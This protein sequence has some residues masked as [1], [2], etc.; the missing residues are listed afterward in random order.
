MENVE[1]PPDAASPPPPLPPKPVVA[2]FDVEAA[3]VAGEAA[4]DSAPLLDGGGDAPHRGAA[5][6]IFAG[7]AALTVGPLLAAGGALHAALPSALQ[8]HTRAGA[9]ALQHGAGVLGAGLK[10]GAVAARDGFVQA[11]T[12][13]VAAMPQEVKDG[14]A[15]AQRGAVAAK[16]AALVGTGIAV[17]VLPREFRDV[18]HASRDAVEKLAEAGRAVERLLKDKAWRGRDADGKQPQRKASR[19]RGAICA[20]PHALPCQPFFNYYRTHLA[21]VLGCVHACIS[22]YMCLTR[23]TGR[24]HFSVQ[25]CSS[26]TRTRRTIWWTRSS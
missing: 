12:F 23:S 10:S 17:S 9:D 5:G 20:R 4:S 13:V 6:D 19:T 11:G 25:S 16:D 22:R 8:Q 7:L 21:Y 18:A 2:A 24:A 14:L 1:P 3:P 26:T 15:V